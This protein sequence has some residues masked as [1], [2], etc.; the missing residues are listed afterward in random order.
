MTKENPAL[1]TD[2]TV[3]PR[4]E[5]GV[6]R[7]KVRTWVLRL[8]LFLTILGP[9]IFILAAPGYKMGLWDLGTA[10]GKMTREIGP[11]VLIAGAVVSFIGL[12]LAFIMQ[13]RK[14]FVVAIIGLLV[15]ALGLYHLSNVQKTVQTLPFIHDVTTDTQDVPMFTDV[16]MSERAAVEGVNTADYIGKTAPTRDAEGN[17]GQELVSVLQTKAYPDI[18]S[19]VLSESKDVVFGKVEAVVNQMGWELKNSDLEAGLIEATDTTFW[20]GFQDDVIVRLRDSEGGGTLVDVRS[21]SR[22][23]GS[24]IGKNAD[25]I[26]EFF[27]VLNAA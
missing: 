10:L 16:I 18:R 17:S 5:S 3:V 8:A 7:R 23:G 27:K 11:M 14:G 4:R 1:K 19:I 26:R 21:L 20:Y 25:R 9:L 13:P 12:L 15:P 22:I 6:K 24:D 2:M